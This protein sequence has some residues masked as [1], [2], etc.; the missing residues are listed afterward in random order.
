MLGK[1]FQLRIAFALL[2]IVACGALLLNHVRT[3]SASSTAGL[4]SVIVELRDD[5]AAVYKAKVEKSGGRVTDEALQS[6]R[7]QLRVKQDQFLD[8]LRAQGVNFNVESV[9]INDF[10][11]QLAA[12]IDYRFTLVYNGVT[13]AVPAAAIPF[14]KSMPQVKGV[15][16]NGLLHIALERSVD[17]V[18]APPVYGKTQELTAFDDLREGYEG[19]GM[20]IAVLDTGIEW[21]H[22]MFGGDP[23]PPRLGVAPPTAA[24]NT[25][26]KVIYYLPLGG[27]IDGFGHG[28]HAASPAAG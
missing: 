24:L 22:D 25:N 18:Q 4:S 7:D 23:T 8:A 15:Q 10:T 1:F 5:P 9:N 16:Q 28:T 13:L 12:K 27:T 17:Y 6:Y 11:G 26:K 3:T 19:Q 2:V 14:I 20:N 21:A